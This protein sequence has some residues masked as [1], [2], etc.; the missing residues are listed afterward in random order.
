[1]NEMYFKI[2][3]IQKK[4]DSN[5]KLQKNIRKFGILFIFIVFCF[6]K[7]DSDIMR[8]TW[9]LTI[10][11]IV[12]LFLLEVYYIKQNIRYEFEI[13]SLE[14]S[15]QER[16]K[17]LSDI[18]G[19]ILPDDVLNPNITMPSNEFSLPILYYAIILILDVM[20]RVLV[21]R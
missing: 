21:I 7:Y 3:G 14:V 20:I 13:Y 11:I 12:L 2:A 6:S 16:K 10:L 4:I 18:T 15:E 9:I 8:L 17:E 1:M 5:I 19:A